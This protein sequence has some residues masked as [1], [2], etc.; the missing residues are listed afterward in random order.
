MN[1]LVDYYKSVRFIK[2]ERK[3]NA[4]GNSL[5]KVVLCAGKY[6]QMKLIIITKINANLALMNQKNTTCQRCSE[7]FLVWLILKSSGGDGKDDQQFR[8]W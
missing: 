1:N 3:L 8:E 2:L 5:T 4:L 6:T 7:M